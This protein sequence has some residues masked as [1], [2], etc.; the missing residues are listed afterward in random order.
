MFSNHGLLFLWNPCFPSIYWSSYHVSTERKQFET[1]KLTHYF[2][3]IYNGVISWTQSLHFSSW[4]YFVNF[5]ILKT[6]IETNITSFFSRLTHVLFSIYRHNFSQI[7]NQIVIFVCSKAA[8]RRHDKIIFYV[9]C[10][11]QGLN[12]PSTF[13]SVVCLAIWAI[14]PH[15][16]YSIFKNSKELHFS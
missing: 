4:T 7:F 16:V 10:L 13:Q 9:S 12:S 3:N 2:C 11:G 6:E 8:N 5:K 1:I 15:Q 14:P